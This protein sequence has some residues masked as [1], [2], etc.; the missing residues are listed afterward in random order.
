MNNILRST[1][2]LSNLMR[3]FNLAR[4]SGK[5]ESGR[6]NRALGIVQR[7]STRLLPDG[8]L[9]INVNDWHMATVSKCDCIDSRRV[10]YCKHKIAAM[11]VYR[12]R[13]YQQG[14][15]R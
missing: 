4:L 1:V 11:I 14:I 8:R 2:T 9:D 12:A 3:A 15:I 13:Q 5:F 7:N 6:L 10:R